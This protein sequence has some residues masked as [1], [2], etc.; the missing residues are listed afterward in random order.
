MIGSDTKM[1]RI[2]R[3]IFILARMIAGRLRRWSFG[4]S[5]QNARAGLG[6]P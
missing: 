5:A 3:A 4:D 6:A 2:A 1:A